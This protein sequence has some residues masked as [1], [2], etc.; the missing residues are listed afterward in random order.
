[1]ALLSKFSLENKVAIITGGGR[2]IG[3]AIAVSFAQAGAH[4]TVAE[5][6]SGSA[7]T[8]AAEIRG[9]GRESLVTLTDVTDAKQ[10][11]KMVELTVAQFGRI[12]ILVNN[13]GA[14]HAMIP[15]VQMSEEVWDESLRIDLKSVFLC[16]KAVGKVMLK[17][18]KGNIINIASAAGHRGVPGIA[19]YAAAK[20]GIINFTKSLAIELARY[21]IRVNAISPGATETELG[22]SVRGTPQERVERAGIPLG[23]IGY[24]EDIANAAVYLASDASDW[25]TGV[26]IEVWGGPYSRKGDLEMFLAKFP[27]LLAAP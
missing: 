27:D 16:S 15:V 19:A 21:Q 17:Q 11:A 13:A 6:D 23:R 22:S 9:L 18:N 24:P 20:A 5:I 10:V 12:D 3:K 8:T 1:M 26:D 14:T 4:V 7:E 25:V 2:G